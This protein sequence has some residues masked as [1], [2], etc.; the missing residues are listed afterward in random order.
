[1]KVKE[2]YK[3]PLVITGHG[4]DVYDLPFRDNH[5]KTKL[6]EVFNNADRLLTV[7]NMNREY[8]IK[9]GIKKEVKIFP[10]GY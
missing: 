5:W 7:S 6:R 9:L 10:N 1:M 2:K 3:K 4:Y 8:L